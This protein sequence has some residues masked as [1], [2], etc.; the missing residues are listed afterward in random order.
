MPEMTAMAGEGFPGGKEGRSSRENRRSS[1]YAAL[2]LGD[3]P[4]P[5]GEPGGRLGALNAE[6]GEGLKALPAKEGGVWESEE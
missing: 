4:G 1:A 5:R 2:S 6:Q 3:S